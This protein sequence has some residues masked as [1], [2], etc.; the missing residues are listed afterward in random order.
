MNRRRWF[1]QGTGEARR[2]VFVLCWQVGRGGFTVVQL[3]LVGDCEAVGRP[4]AFIYS[5]L[6]NFVIQLWEWVPLCPE[7]LQTQ[8]HSPPRAPPQGVRHMIQWCRLS[9]T[10][11]EGGAANPDLRAN[12]ARTFTRTLGSVSFAAPCRGKWWGLISSL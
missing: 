3:R 9:P 5:R 6:R 12:R 11:G 4:T 2:S 8:P 10:Q 7:H 1:Q